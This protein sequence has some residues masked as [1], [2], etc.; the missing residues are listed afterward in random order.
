MA[1]RSP[2]HFGPEGNVCPVQGW[3]SLTA[4]HRQVIVKYPLHAGSCPHGAHSH[5]VE[6][7]I[8]REDVSDGKRA[9]GFPRGPSTTEGPRLPVLNQGLG[10]R[11]GGPCT[12][13]KA[14]W[15]REAEGM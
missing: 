10:V 12:I 14:A 13:V 15:W 5:R 6:Q 9:G 3:C 11:A 1:L 4:P 7:R 2:G 8:G